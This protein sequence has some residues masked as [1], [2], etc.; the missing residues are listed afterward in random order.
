MS[1]GKKIPL[2]KK[3]KFVRKNYETVKWL[4]EGKNVHLATR[5]IRVINIA[6]KVFDYSDKTITGDIVSGLRKAFK[7]VESE[8]T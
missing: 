6:R 4:V 5:A 3:K 8:N 2:D 7:E 1:V